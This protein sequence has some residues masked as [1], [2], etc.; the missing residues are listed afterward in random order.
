MRLALKHVREVSHLLVKPTSLVWSAMTFFH[1]FFADTPMGTFPPNLFASTCLFV[2]AK[3]SRRASQPIL[4][5]LS[6]IFSCFL[7]FR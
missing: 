4:S 5:P 7:A 2:A 1:R 6:L 3:V